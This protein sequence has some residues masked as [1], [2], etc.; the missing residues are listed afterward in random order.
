M[1]E[2]RKV[3]H[4]S[5][6]PSECHVRM[7]Q[8]PC[9]L[10]GTCFQALQMSGATPSDIIERLVRWLP[11]LA[12]FKQF[13]E[14]RDGL[15]RLARSC[16]LKCV[17]PF[18]NLITQGD[19]EESPCAYVIVQGSFVLVKDGKDLNLLSTGDCVGEL[20]ALHKEKK[21]TATLMACEESLVL[22]FPN[23]VFK[24]CVGKVKGLIAQ[25]ELCR[26]ALSKDPMQR[27][28]DDLKQLLNLCHQS[29]FLKQFDDSTLRLVCRNM[30]YCIM[31]KGDI[32]FHQGER[33]HA[34]YI[35]LSGVA[36]I[37]KQP[38]RDAVG[39]LLGQRVAS[40]EAGDAF[41]ELAL[42]DPEK[43]RNASIVA[44]SDV[45]ELASP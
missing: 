17:L 37:F 24:E 32:V 10:P 12:F 14:D 33:G 19:E 38:L 29:A 15:L 23:K 43:R 31:Q 25:P 40:L 3:Q 28:A 35:I 22:V 30:N 21:R 41:G 7:V 44:G 4:K 11:T 8:P 34:F 27:N 42:I 5:A 26:V 2:H 1:I 16:S 9:L 45:L 18:S 6:L 20:A 36:E 39:Q 13:K